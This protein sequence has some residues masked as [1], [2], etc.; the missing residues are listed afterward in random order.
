MEYLWKILLVGKWFLCKTDA[1]QKTVVEG[2]EKAA[3]SMFGKMFSAI[4]FRP[5]GN[6]VITFQRLMGF[7][8]GKCQ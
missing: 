7:N 2:E 1:I 8:R 4:K 5:L 6:N 3:D